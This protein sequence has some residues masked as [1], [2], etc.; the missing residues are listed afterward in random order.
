MYAIRLALAFWRSN[1]LWRILVFHNFSYCHKYIMLFLEA[2]ENYFG[3]VNLFIAA[4]PPIT[5]RKDATMII[6]N[7]YNREC[8][9]PQ[10]VPT[11][12]APEKAIFVATKWELSRI[13]YFR[14]MA[15]ATRALDLSRREIPNWMADVIFNYQGPIL[16]PD[17][18]VFKIS[19]TAI[20]DRLQQRR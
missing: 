7:C 15:I 2:V 10:A 1:R 9:Q 4:T 8:F 12:P 14:R 11:K 20:D 18:R 17:G 5:K 16:W 13:W 6:H 19:A 3:G